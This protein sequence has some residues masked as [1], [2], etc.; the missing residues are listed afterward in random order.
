M[1]KP[2]AAH[3]ELIV[4]YLPERL[5]RPEELFF[6]RMRSTLYR[7]TMDSILEGEWTK[8]SVYLKSNQ[9]CHPRKQSNGY[10]F[11]VYLPCTAFGTFL[12]SLLKL[13]VW[14]RAVLALLSDFVCKY[15]NCSVA[16]N[17]NACT[18]IK[19]LQC[20]S[21]PL[22]PCVGQTKSYHKIQFR[23]RGTF[24]VW[25]CVKNIRLK[26][27]SVCVS[28]YQIPPVSDI[29]TKYTPHISA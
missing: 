20:R 9:R 4:Y 22:Q 17:V 29:R 14:A 16:N 24:C 7:R 15:I 21:H 19:H 10:F 26:R 3:Q 12:S 25:E 18:L 13:H 6:V 23:W 8:K 28:F 27:I 5:D 2:L 1:V 11:F